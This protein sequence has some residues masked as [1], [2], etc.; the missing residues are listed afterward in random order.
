MWENNYIILPRT[1]LFHCSEKLSLSTTV[2]QCKSSNF[3]IIILGIMGFPSHPPE[4]FDSHWSP[5]PVTSTMI[6]IWSILV[7]FNRLLTLKYQVLHHNDNVLYN[8]KDHCNFFKREKYVWRKWSLHTLLVGM[9]N[10]ATSVD[11]LVVPQKAKCRFAIRPS[12]STPRQRSKR[13][14]S[15]GD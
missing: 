5:L 4:L 6:Y 15:R 7:S 1:V 9:Q 10:W 13:T 12:N 2:K 3:N 8:N 11:K 14:A